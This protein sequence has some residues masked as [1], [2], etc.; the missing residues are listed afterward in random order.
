[1][2]TR[3]RADRLLVERGLFASR[4]R[5]QAAIAAGLVRADDVVVRK[6]SDE[7]ALGA[8]LDAIEEHPFVSRGGIKLSAALDHFGFDPKGRVG[9]DVGAST[10]GFTDVLIG[11]GARIVYAVDVGHAQLHARLRGRPD[12]H[13]FEDTDIRKLDPARLPE[14]PDIVVIDVSF[15]SSIKVLPAALGLAHVP[16]KWTPVRREEHA[17]LRDSHAPAQLVALV[18]PQFEAGRRHLKKGI[19]RDA[20]VQRAACD[21]VAAA[22]TALDW[23]VLGVIASPLRGRD[24]NC[25]F[26][27][28]A[29]K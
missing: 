7:I 26:L 28:G 4:A 21:A 19:V 18:K 8:R 20:S 23:R 17:P 2:T 10:G 24:G 12:V 9:L 6:A 16:A 29:V 1:M 27:L 25:E 15:V 22:V 14:P 13:A 11:R 5:A 3:L